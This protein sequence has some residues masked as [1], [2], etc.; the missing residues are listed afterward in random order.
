MVSKTALEKIGYLDEAVPSFQ[1]WDTSIRLARECRFIHV[2]EPL[3]IYHVNSTDSISRD[4]RR[5]IAG[6]QYIVDKHEKEI[7][8]VCGH[9]IWER[10]LFIQLEKCLTFRLWNEADEYL[11]RIN[12]R[13][14]KYRIFQTFRNLRLS[15]KLLSRLGVTLNRPLAKIE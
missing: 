14:L 9:E 1:E 7:E 3:F 13:S 2:R 4:R 8:T 15:P 10:H 12:H 5:D 6:Y 11:D